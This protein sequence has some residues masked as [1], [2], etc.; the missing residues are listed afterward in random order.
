MIRA[1]LVAIIPVSFSEHIIPC[2]GIR[3][4][5]AQNGAAAVKSWARARGISEKDIGQA[6]RCLG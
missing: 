4:A 5:V 1:I 3:R 2:W 6:K